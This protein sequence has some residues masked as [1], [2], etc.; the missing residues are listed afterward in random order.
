[1]EEKFISV[2]IPTYKPSEYLK[3][4][5][6]SLRRQTLSANCFEIII[7]L[8][9]CNEPFFSEI[10]EYIETENL[11]N[12]TIIHTNKQGVSNARNLGIDAAKGEYITFID[13]DDWISENYLSQLLDKANHNSIVETNVI[14]Y[15]N[16]TQRLCYGYLA[17]AFNNKDSYNDNLFKNRSF[18]STSCCKIIPQKIISDIR[19]DTS[20]ANDEDALF[21][22]EISKNIKSI[23][24]T[25][26]SAVYFRRL[27]ENSA[28]RKHVA[29]FKKIK[30]A[31][32]MCIKFIMTYMNSPKQYN[33]LLL[34]S[35]IVA[36]IIKIVK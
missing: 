32:N 15:N 5:L 21:M 34:A 19:F 26:Y 13:D 14:D 12:T 11:A 30:H 18:L 29:T 28:S 33:F 8:N 6:H 22:F 23:M 9:G 1:M 31:T 10:K 3:E 27:T 17:K 25:D 16:K 20:I 35:R 2:I 7:I 36:S 4:C 24:F